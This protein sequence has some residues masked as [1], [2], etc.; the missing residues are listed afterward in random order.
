MT[1]MTRSLPLPL[2][3]P[4]RRRKSGAA[5]KGRLTDLNVAKDFLIFALREIPGSG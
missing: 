5:A 3:P 4:A 2:A 1:P